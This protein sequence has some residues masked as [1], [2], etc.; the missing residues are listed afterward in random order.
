MKQPNIKIFDKIHKIRLIDYDQNEQI[1]RLI[2]YDEDGYEYTVYRSNTIINDD[3]TTVR[4]IDKPTKH[5]YMRV[6]YAPNLEQLIDP[7]VFE[8]TDTQN[9]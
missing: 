3:L 8:K 1:D 9:I 6:I 5:P 4:K 2:Y 7:N